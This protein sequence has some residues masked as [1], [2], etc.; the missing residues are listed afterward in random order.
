MKVDSDLKYGRF[1]VG[2][3]KLIRFQMVW[4]WGQVISVWDGVSGVKWQRG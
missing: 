3:K 1:K 4:D 2:K